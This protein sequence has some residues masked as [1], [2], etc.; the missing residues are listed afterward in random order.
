MRGYRGQPARVQP[1]RDLSLTV[2]LDE[3][4]LAQAIHQLGWGVYGTNQ[5]AAQLSVAQAVLAHREEYLIERGLG[6]LQGHP[7]SLRP[8][9]LARDDHATGLVRLLMIGLR[10]LTVL[11]F[12]VRRRLAAEGAAVA[13]LYAGQ[14]TRATTRPTAEWLLA[15]FRDITL[16][17]VQL[18]DHILR[19]VTPLTPLQERILT[20]LDCSP[21]IYLRLATDSDQPP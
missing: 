8:L 11:A 15:N 3:A 4:A 1:E 14:P 5:P 12:A 21:V 20:L 7:L 10:V 18:P 9:Y 6:R 17:L 16:T 19:H 13:S 2:T